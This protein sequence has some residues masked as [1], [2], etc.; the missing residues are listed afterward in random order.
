MEEIGVRV[1][2]PRLLATVSTANA[3]QYY[4]LVDL[5]EGMGTFE[6]QEPHELDNHYNP[7]W[8]HASQLMSLRVLPAG[9]AELVAQGCIDGRWPDE[10][11]KLE[12]SG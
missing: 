12:E 10:A 6:W 2:A 11:V 5:P 3:F 7:V 4:F 8:V 9:V 1:T